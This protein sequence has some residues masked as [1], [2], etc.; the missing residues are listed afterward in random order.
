LA[1][2]C[3]RFCQHKDWDGHHKV[4]AISA[5]GNGVI[6]TGSGSI[7]ASKAM[8]SPPMSSSNGVEKGSSK[9]IEE[10]STHL[11]GGKVER[12]KRQSHKKSSSN[13]DNDDNNVNSYNNNNNKDNKTSPL[14][15]KIDNE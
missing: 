10:K 12:K 3:S 13:E 15:L 9:L 11:T 8:Q 7:F 1:K 6:S 2:Y 4:C 5:A 14:G